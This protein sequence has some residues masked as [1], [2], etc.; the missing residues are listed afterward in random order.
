MPLILF[1]N[2]ETENVPIFLPLSTASST[3]QH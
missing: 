2:E 1:K 3:R